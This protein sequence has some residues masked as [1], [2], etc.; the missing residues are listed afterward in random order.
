MKYIYSLIFLCFCYNGNAQ[1]GKLQLG[2]ETGN[3]LAY[4]SY[5]GNG[6]VNGNL[7]LRYS[8]GILARYKFKTGFKVKRQS[9]TFIPYQRW[10]FGIGFW[11]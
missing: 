11:L 9:I 6:N 1:N 7:L 10:R 8:A 5:F 2:F 3:H 4:S